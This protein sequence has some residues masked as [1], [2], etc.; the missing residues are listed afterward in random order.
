MSAV[1][2]HPGTLG[3][4]TRKLS[5]WRTLQVRNMEWQNRGV[6]LEPLLAQHLHHVRSKER[7]IILHEVDG[8]PRTTYDLAI[9]NGE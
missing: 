3:P 4:K 2:T 6:N 8:L 1:A 9:F 5:G 7:A